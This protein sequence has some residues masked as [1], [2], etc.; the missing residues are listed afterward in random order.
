MR[1]SALNPILTREDIPPLGGARDVSSVFNPGAVKHAGR[2]ILLSRVQTR[3]RE[4]LLAVA[5]SPDGRRFEVRS[6][7]V[8]IDGIESVPERIYHLYDPRITPLDGAYYVVLAADTEQACRL[9]ILRTDDFVRFEL[10]AYDTSDD[11]RNGVLFPEKLDGR[12]VRLERPNTVSPPGGPLTGSAIS[13]STS[14][15]LRSWR[16]EG[17]VLEGRPRYW[18]EL[19]GAGPPPL[20][21]SAGWLL[22]YHGVAT[23]FGAANIYQA[24][25]ALL[26]PADPRRLIARGR[27]N[28]LEPRERYELMGQVPGVVFPT[29][30]IAEDVGADGC[31]RDGSVVRLYYGAADTC[32]C[33]AT[34]T[35]AELL[36]E[37]G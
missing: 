25:V 31:A 23:H 5:E 14:D 8:R 15:D 6:E 19:I 29:G 20:K 28:I 26:D 34:T 33:L 12:Y 10:V 1:R 21:T 32:V 11:M 30:L 3:G 36:A 17:V 2:Y 27:E 4:T 18:D 7:P 22:I 35:V 16:R 9:V 13:L 37:L 24:G